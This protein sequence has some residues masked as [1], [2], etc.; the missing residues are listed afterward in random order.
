MPKAAPRVMRF[1][2]ADFRPRFE[3]GDQ[4]QAANLCGEADGSEL[5]S[6]LVRLTNARIPWTIKYDEVVLVLEGALTIQTGR[7]CSFGK[8]IGLNMAASRNKVNI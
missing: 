3:Y 7:W 4:A 5:G 8:S 1:R 6:G 2:D